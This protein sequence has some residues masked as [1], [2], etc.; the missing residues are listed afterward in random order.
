M[1]VAGQK[2]VATRGKSGPGTRGSLCLSIHPCTF[3]RQRAGWG[4]W[5]QPLLNGQ[6]SQKRKEM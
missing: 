1:R 3:I 5:T 2:A 6:F 4:L